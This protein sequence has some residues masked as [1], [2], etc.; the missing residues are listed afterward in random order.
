V[1]K[2]VNEDG[3]MTV[4]DRWGMVGTDS[5]DPFFESAGYRWLDKDSKG[6]LAVNEALEG[7]Y[8]YGDIVAQSFL[9]GDWYLN[10][11]RYRGDLEGNNV[12]DI[13]IGTF[14]KGNA[15]LYSTLAGEIDKVQKYDVE[16]GIL[17]FPKESAAQEAYYAPCSLSTVSVIAI[18]AG[19]KDPAFSAYMLE[20]LACEGGNYLQPVYYTTLMDPA[21]LTEI[22]AL[23]LLVASFANVN[24]DL[25]NLN[26]INLGNVIRSVVNENFLDNTE[27][28]W[29]AL[30]S[31]LQQKL[32]EF[33]ENF[34]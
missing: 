8:S 10:T 18:P 12:W 3:F 21:V 15:L 5:V 23:E 32:S 22:P 26:Q 13:A 7:H 6:L 20:V 9:Y 16:Y 19:V 4:S 11:Q 33:N 2:D 17:P 25:I 29:T 31:T 34:S 1:T 27:K 28:N 24:Y 30:Q 14:G